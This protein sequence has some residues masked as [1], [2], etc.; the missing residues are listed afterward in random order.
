MPVD[1]EK[2][3]AW[4]D[5]ALEPVDAAA[6][7]DA[8]AADPA[9][10]ALA[11]SHRRL[12][13]R[14]RGGFNAILHEPIPAALAAVVRPAATVID[15]SAARRTR[16]DRSAAPVGRRRMPQ[17]AA[18]AATLAVGIVAG[19]MA[20][21]FGPQP[22][23]TQGRSGL[24]ASGQLAA[25]LDDELASVPVRGPV[26]VHVT[27]RAHDGQ[28]CRTWSTAG[29]DGVACHSGDRWRI[30]ASVAASTVDTEQYRMAGNSN[31]K[32]LGIIDG[33]IKGET[34]DAQQEVQA[35]RS[36]WR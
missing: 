9:L 15:L 6:V 12:T 17:W 29:Q 13:T 36:G 34:F 25:A 1:E 30:V 24:Q 35:R 23:L 2:L 22:I 19:R 18:I 21:E 31:Q 7:A 32:L 20:G 8:V 3:I 11:E 27:F 16:D 14:L 4:I 10:A 26:R 5:G 33:M 28:I